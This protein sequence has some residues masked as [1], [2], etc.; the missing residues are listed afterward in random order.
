[1]MNLMQKVADPTFKIRGAKQWARLVSKAALVKKA[2]YLSEFRLMVALDSGNI[3]VVGNAK[4]RTSPPSGATPGQV[5]AMQEMYVQTTYTLL[6]VSVVWLMI[7]CTATLL[8]TS[9]IAY[10]GRATMSDFCSSALTGFCFE[11]GISDVP[12]GEE[13]IRDPTVCNTQLVMQLLKLILQFGMLIAESVLPTTQCYPDW[14]LRT[15]NSHD[16]YCH[17]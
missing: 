13:S 8:I 1:M 9:E 4:T 17:W 15:N 5:L 2:E 16:S 11:L 7:G 10:V 14:C 12:G 3:D 6:P